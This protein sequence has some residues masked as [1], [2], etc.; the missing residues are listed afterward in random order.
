MMQLIPI[1]MLIAGLV[2]KAIASYP[3]ESLWAVALVVA[4]RVCR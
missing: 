4:Y 3:E 1:F 2:V